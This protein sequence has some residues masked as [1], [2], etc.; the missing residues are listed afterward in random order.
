MAAR[1]TRFRGFYGANPL[2]LL[3]LVAAF[4]LAAHAALNAITDGSWRVVLAWFLGAVV[5][6]DLV[7][8]PLYA[9]ADRSLGAALRAVR[10]RA[11]TTEL[12]VSPV[13]YL[14][15]P[16]LGCGLLFL[17]FFPGIIQQGRLSYLAATGLTQQP[18]L[19]RWLL[20]TAALF[21]ASALAYAIRLAVATGRN[22]PT[23]T[24]PEP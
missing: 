16:A 11:A 22:R 19:G 20:L 2:H 23:T 14:R 1:L 8:F 18:Y 5:G 17:M 10:P 6:H 24:V 7:L 12:L 13:N 21:T 15:V 4:A 3:T 9:V